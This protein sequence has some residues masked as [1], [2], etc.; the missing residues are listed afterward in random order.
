[1][2]HKA[3]PSV[4]DHHINL[5]PVLDSFVHHGFNLIVLAHVAHD[6]INRTTFLTNT[7]S[8]RTQMIHR[9]ARNQNFGA[10]P[11]KLSGN[12]RPNASAATCHNRHLACDIKSRVCHYDTYSMFMLAQ[13]Y[14]KLGNQLLPPFEVRKIVPNP[15]TTQPCCA[16]RKSIARSHVI[17][18]MPRLDFSQLP[19]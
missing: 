19:F 17:I 10:A 18:G 12:I 5:A 14:P 8:H 9:P 2:R 15:P 1:M 7:V 4:I 6:R 3:R 16:S 13:T 11:T